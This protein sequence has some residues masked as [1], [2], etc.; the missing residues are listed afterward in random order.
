MSH[1]TEVLW[2]ACFANFSSFF[3]LFVYCF[4]VVVDCFGLLLAGFQILTIWSTYCYGHLLTSLPNK[5]HL[6]LVEMTTLNNEKE[7]NKPS[8]F[9]L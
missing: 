8:W 2:T 6:L 7:K 1:I 5:F 9:A 4:V 3:F